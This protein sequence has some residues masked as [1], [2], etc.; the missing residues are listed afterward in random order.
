MSDDNKVGFDLPKPDMAIGEV[1]IG[2]DAKPVTEE[3]DKNISEQWSK[4]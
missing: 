3:E 2:G 1:K 4:V